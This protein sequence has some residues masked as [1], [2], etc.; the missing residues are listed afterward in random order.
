MTSS[1][2]QLLEGV[3]AIIPARGGDLYRGGG[4]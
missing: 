3:L 4:S 2:T 1:P